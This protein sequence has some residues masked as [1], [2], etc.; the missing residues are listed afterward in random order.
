MKTQR[1]HLMYCKPITG[2]LRADF[3]GN[4]VVF[5]KV[6]FHQVRWLDS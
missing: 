3:G 6:N 4:G 2:V 5:G 1:Q